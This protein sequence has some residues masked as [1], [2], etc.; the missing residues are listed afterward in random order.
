V[1]TIFVQLIHDRIHAVGYDF[2]YAFLCELGGKEIKNIDL[3]AWNNFCVKIAAF[4]FSSDQ[5]DLHVRG[6]E[7]MWPEAVAWINQLRT[8]G[9]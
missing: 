1:Y 3:V 7:S 9:L 8:E 4:Y 6:D 2:E 5:Q